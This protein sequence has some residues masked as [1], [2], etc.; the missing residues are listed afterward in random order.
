M[1]AILIVGLSTHLRGGITVWRRTSQRIDAMQRRRVALDQ[2]ERDLSNAI[3]YDERPDAYG[4]PPGLL[5]PVEFGPSRLAWYAVVPAGQGSDATVQYVEYWCDAIDGPRSLWRRSRSIAQART[6]IGPPPQ[7]LL[8]GCDA[9]AAQYAYKPENA[10]QPL[11]WQAQWTEALKPPQLVAVSVQ[12]GPGEQVR[13]TIVVAQGILPS[14]GAA[15]AG[16]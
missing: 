7:L 5:P 8:P 15:P 2:L 16:P 13:R 1:L 12:L 6:G 9:L 10:S 14:I 4:S 11:L 3:I